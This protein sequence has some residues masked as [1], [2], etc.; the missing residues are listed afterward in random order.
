LDVKADGT[1]ERS[2]EADRLR[3]EIRQNL[4]EKPSEGKS[5]TTPPPLVPTPP[6]EPPKK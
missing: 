6:P 1:R 2:P 4:M 5:Q 3:N